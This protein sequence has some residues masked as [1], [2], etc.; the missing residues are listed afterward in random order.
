MSEFGAENGESFLARLN[1]G[2]RELGRLLAQKIPSS[3][4][5]PLQLAYRQQPANTRPLTTESGDI[6]H[7]VK[8]TRCSLYSSH[9][10]D[11]ERS[12][13]A[14]YCNDRLA[15]LLQSR[16]MLADLKEENEALREVLAR[17]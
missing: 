10:T 7:D 11:S 16:R 12:G 4:T 9:I 1:A 13:K 5:S 3:V 17:R 15:A 14:F 8:Q 6:E 2:K